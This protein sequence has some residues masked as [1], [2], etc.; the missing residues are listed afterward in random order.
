MRG[1]VGRRADRLVEADRRRQ[2]PLEHGV[3]HEVVVAE[4]LLDHQQVQGVELLEHPEV[5]QARTPR[6]RR[7]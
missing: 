4:R 3:V 2:V 5:V 1:G 6:S 7:R